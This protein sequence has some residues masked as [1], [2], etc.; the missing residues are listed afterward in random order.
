MS[1]LIFIPEKARRGGAADA[2]RLGGK[3]ANLARLAA[4]PGIAVPPWF[5]LTAE[6]YREHIRSSSISPALAAELAR[7]ER[8]PAEAA[9]QIRALIAETP[10]PRSVRRAL[11]EACRDRFASDDFLAVRSSAVGED[12]A[13]FS[14]AGQLDSFLYVRGRDAVGDAVRRCWASA[15][16]DRAVAYRRERGLS[17]VAVAVAVVVQRMVPARAAGVAFTADPVSGDRGV[18]VV[19]AAWGLG[20]GVVQGAFTTDT[21]RL[22][23]AGGAVSAEIRRK[24]RRCVFDAARGAGTRVEDVPPDLAERPCLEQRALDAL[25]AAAVEIERAFGAPQDIE[26]AVA[27]ERL[28][29]L[30]ARPIT[31]LPPAPSG[32]ER[33]IWDNSNIVESYA[34]VTTPLTFSFIRRAYA[35]V[36]DQFLAAMG[37]PPR[38][39]RANADLF[40]HLLGLARGCVYY[41]LL[42]WYALLR[43]FP[44]YAYNREFMENMMG[45][46]ERLRD[47]H[48]ERETRLSFVRRYFVELPRLIGVAM[49]I[50]VNF[51]A[52]DGRMRRFLA[53][54]HR[55]HARFSALPIE[56]MSPA[57]L[58][59][60]YR[61]MEER[62]LRRWKPPIL[63]DF[64]AMIF[65]G[66]LRKIIVGW[67]VDPEG[68]LQNDLLCG[69]EQIES[70]QAAIALME[71]ARSVRADPA[72]RER[73]RTQ[74]AEMLAANWRAGAL[75]P[76]ARDAFERYLEQFGDRGMNELKLEAPK[77]REDPSFLFSALKNYVGASDPPDPETMARR[78]RAAREAAEARAAERLGRA[79]WGWGPRRIT[80]FRWV[81]RETR[82]HVRN[83]ENQR[84]ART[85]AFSLVRRIFLALGARL[86]SAGALA[87]ADDVFYLTVNEIFD[88]FEQGGDAARLS[89]VA[90]ARKTEFEE[91]RKGPTPPNRFETRGPLNSDGSVPWNPPPAPAETRGIG[92]GADILR[93]T[94]CCGGVV[95]GPVRVIRSPA[96]DLRLNG[97]ILV[98]EKTDPGWIPLYPSVSG[99]LIERGSVLSHS[100]I[101]AR[102][103]GK[104][105]IVGIEGLTAALRDG[106]RVEMDGA[107]GF[108]RKLSADRSVGGRPT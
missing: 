74:S 5:A 17:P 100:A 75:P 4:L 71:I 10:L 83:R 95:R 39:R 103:M 13:S 45:V 69:D 90:A 46:R 105:A 48:A 27:D 78:Q 65:Y 8:A 41:N 88:F 101:V 93:G 54:F 77:P 43:F 23:K 91:Y 19:N 51:L 98:A 81:L 26:F 32:G 63:S 82:R 28:F 76:S 72:A 6:A 55:R 44:G 14:C 96:D 86:E 89:A 47:D 31:T 70:A 87:K 24:D 58:M 61:E 60:L 20:E 59:A 15:F 9:A 34:G 25:R 66:V 37:V 12:S 107:A 36:Y 49:R 97:E 11:A 80:V 38:V 42:N 92:A 3:A 79:R 67:G 108:V 52:V 30:Q 18:I 68:A 21:W 85:R 62:I 1:A 7:R 57:E 22:P 104:P 73:F 102:E 33:R 2:A 16:S 29:I 56:R 40:D 64:Y 106:D 35:A 84:M 53:E 99:L 50:V 94:P